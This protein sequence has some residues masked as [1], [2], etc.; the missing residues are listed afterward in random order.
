VHTMAD[1]DL[2]DRVFELNKLGAEVA[3]AACEKYAT[4]DRP[5][6]VVGSIGPGTKLVSLGQ[7]D[8]DTMS[9]SYAEQVRGLLAGGADALLIETAQDILQV[10]CA[11]NAALEV[12]KE[13]NLSPDLDGT[14]DV[15]IMAQ[16]TI[17]QFGTTLI[18]TDIA[19]VVAALHGY[20]IF[21]LGMN[22]ATGPGEMAEHLSYLAQNWRKRISLLPN[23]GLP[24]LSEGK[25]VFP[26]QPEP[27][28][29][30]VAEYVETMGLNIVG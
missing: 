20:P 24:A 25:T 22:C 10:K 21:S 29:D 18:G 17:E 15:P 5:R 4:K 2:S 28:A 1:Q 14:G 7:I 8:W 23:A 30:K 6:F 13:K 9:A 11:I 26:L 3:R 19:G 16:V 27:F 12:L